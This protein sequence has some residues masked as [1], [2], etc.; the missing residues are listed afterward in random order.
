MMTESHGRI[1]FSFT[2]SNATIAC[3][4]TTIYFVE[5]IDK[6]GTDYNLK[7]SNFM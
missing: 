7:Q 1:Y 6:R 3:P 5:Y 2:L 4:V